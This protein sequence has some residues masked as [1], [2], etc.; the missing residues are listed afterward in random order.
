M[1]IFEVKDHVFESS[2]FINILIIACGILMVDA[3]EQKK[4]GD[5]SENKPVS[6]A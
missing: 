3:N 5:E 2:G 1:S 4:A 6:M